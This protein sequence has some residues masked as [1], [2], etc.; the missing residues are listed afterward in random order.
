MGARTRDG[1]R[2]LEALTPGGLVPRE[3]VSDCRVGAEAPGFILDLL[4][5]PSAVMV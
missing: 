4:P 5:F 3:I 2:W 1:E